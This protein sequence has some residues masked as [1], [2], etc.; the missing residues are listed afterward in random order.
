MS[1]F[2]SKADIKRCGLTREAGAASANPLNWE[3]T[4]TLTLGDFPPE[5]FN[6]GGVATVN[7][8]NS[9]GGN[10]HLSTLRFAQSRGQIGGD[11]TLLVTDP[12]TAGNSIA[13]IQFI[14]VHGGTGTYGQISG[15]ALSTTVLDPNQLPSA[16]VVKLCLLGTT[17]TST[18][19]LIL[20]GPTTVNGVPGTGRK[21]VGIGGL[22]TIG[23]DSPIR[24][25]IED[26]VASSSSTVIW[27]SYFLNSPRTLETPKCRTEK[28]TWEWPGSTM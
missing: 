17:C 3:G 25:S 4:T 26:W 11:S 21:G 28:A 7:S 22:L 15:G 18:L 9:G 2:G 5:L 12:E 24:I 10:T 1:A 20:T 19:D 23:G 8:S 13:A 14:G 27:P 6:G 16:G